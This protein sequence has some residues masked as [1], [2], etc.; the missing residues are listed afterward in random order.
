MYYATGTNL[1]SG[2]GF[3]LDIM[4]QD[5]NQVFQR[6]IRDFDL[7]TFYR[8]SNDKG[9]F[10]PW[11][12]L[13]SQGET[14]PVGPKGEDGV[15]YS[16]NI[17]PRLDKYANNFH[18]NN[19]ISTGMNDIQSGFYRDG[20]W[21]LYYLYNAD[22]S[23]GGN[24]TEW[25]H[26]TT[27]DWVKFENQGVAIHKY[28]T[29]Y[30]DIATGTIWI[31]DNDVIGK[32]KGTIFAM[33]TG[34]GGDKGQNTMLYYSTDNGYNFTAYQEDAVML[35]PKGQEDFRDPYIFKMGDTYVIYHAE[36]NKFGVYTSKQLNTG[37]G[38]VGGYFAPHPLLECPNLF[39]MNVNGDKNN[40]KWVLMYGGNGGDDLQTGTYASVGHLDDNFVFIP[41]FE[42]IR[43][44]WGPDF[45]ASKPFED[46]NAP[47]IH[48]HL[49]CIGWLGS[50]GYVGAV[51]KE[52]R[53]G[54]GASSCRKLRLVQNNGV[55]KITSEVMG[56]DDYLDNPVVGTANILNQIEYNLPRVKG[57]SFKL[58][59]KLK[60]TKNY[61]GNIQI[62]FY[63]YGY[64]TEFTYYFD[65]NNASVHRYNEQFT[66]N[67]IFSKDH[68]FPIDLSS[69][70]DTFMTFYVD[71]V[72][73]EALNQ[74]GTMYTMTKFPLGRS[75]EQIS[76]KADGGDVP[77]EYY[78]Y[79]IT[80]QGE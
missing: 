51:P 36:N 1:P 14:G 2:N 49:L 21:H 55:Y 37:Y 30:G 60:S 27:N 6:A 40:Q 61:K 8:S 77:I 18:L 58:E 78:Y 67:G 73:I 4:S 45:Y 39:V 64:D 20:V 13:I 42:D 54:V 46:T 56:I 66:N 35:H 74:D 57:D 70:V 65:H 44:D 16:P 11:K 25:Y 15:S 29:A 3:Y 22:V 32:G 62:K 53:G 80:K 33:A 79:Q 52:T 71:R 75:R 38:Y 5:E 7:K 47:D 63:G 69:S 17:N 72:V 10:S 19:P 23:W 34:Y 43:C 41:E 76:I 59:I 48:D 26:V 24:G 50:W 28:K 12:E 31:D 68:S 9:E